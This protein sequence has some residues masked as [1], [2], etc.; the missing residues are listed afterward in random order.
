MFNESEGESPWTP[1]WP[2]SKFVTLMDQSYQ[3][4]G[5]LMKDE[6]DKTVPRRLRNQN[7][8]AA[9]ETLSY[10][11]R[12]SER[13]KKNLE[14][15]LRKS[16]DAASRALYNLLKHLERGARGFFSKFEIAL[17]EEKC[18]S[19]TFE[20]IK[21]ELIIYRASLNHSRTPGQT[22]HTIVEIKQIVAPGTSVTPAVFR[23]MVREFKV[24][25]L[26]SK[27]GKGSPRY[28]LANDGAH[29]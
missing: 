8:R 22:R 5:W 17:E 7:G 3:L 9:W 18:S 19:S 25:H 16:S 28:R 4:T 27:R 10:W 29:Q 24:P 12:A 23:N 13:E 21:E 15:R 20:K 14:K 1:E 11:R 6:W 26:P 2:T